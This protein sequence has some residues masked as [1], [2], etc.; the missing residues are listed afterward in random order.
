M[1]QIAVLSDTHGLLRE[2]VIQAIAGSDAIV[3]AGDINNQQ[4]LD[5]LS[6]LA[7]SM[8]CAETMTR[9]GRPI[10]HKT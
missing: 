10:F 2:E 3:H 9:T 4:I 5:R 7:R 8:L 6:A 1:K